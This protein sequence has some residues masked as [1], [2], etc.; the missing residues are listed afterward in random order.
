MDDRQWRELLNSAMG[1]PP[2]QVTA[3]AT[4]RRLQRLRR[5]R[6]TEAFAAAAAVAVAVLGGSAVAGG[7]RSGNSSS[8]HGAPAS[9]PG[10]PAGR[11]HQL[12]SGSPDRDRHD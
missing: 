10:R 7:L 11:I 5:R 9:E 1:E 4:R 8:P 3:E 12:L 6:V 2:G